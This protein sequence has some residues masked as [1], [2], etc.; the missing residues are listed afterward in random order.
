MPAHIFGPN[1]QMSH[2]RMLNVS[3]NYIVQLNADAL[4]GVPYLETLDMSDNEINLSGNESR[5]M[6]GWTTLV[7][8]IILP[9]IM[10]VF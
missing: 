1:V 6:W 5:A 3:S 2:L 4:M 8:C 9:L 7:L 10:P